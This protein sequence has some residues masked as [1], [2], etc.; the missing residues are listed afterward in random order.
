MIQRIERVG[1][2]AL[3][4]GMT[5]AVLFAS[6]AVHAQSNDDTTP[7]GEA[8]PPEVVVTG[9]QV[10][11]SGFVSP[12]PLT[13]FS[14]EQIERSGVDNIGDALNQLPALRATLTPSSATNLFSMTGGNFLDLRGLGAVRTLTL[15]DGKRYVPT[16]P[17]GIVNTNIIP[18]AMIAST[19]IVTGGASAA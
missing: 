16:N 18:Q 4:A 1:K 7:R 17:S 5:S 9:S 12:T 19:D 13:T 14:T 3:A 6:A 8:E 2:R 15:V 10:A 11:R